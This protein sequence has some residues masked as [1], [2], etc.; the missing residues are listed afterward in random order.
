MGGKTNLC[1]SLST[2]LFLFLYSAAG[3]N[4]KTAK[5]SAEMSTLSIE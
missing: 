3:E 1:K 4:T 5:M 2:L